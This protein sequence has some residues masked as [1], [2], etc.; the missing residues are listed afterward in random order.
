[1]AN[2]AKKMTARRPE[3]GRLPGEGQSFFRS[4]LENSL[5]AVVVVNKEGVVQYESPSMER[6][7]GYKLGDRIG[8]SGLELVHP[9]DVEDATS[10][11]SELAQHPGKSIVKE[12]RVRHADGSWRSLH[13]YGKNLLKNPAVRGI[14]AGFLDITERKVSEKELAESEEYYRALS[15]SAEKSGLGITIVQNTQ[16]REAAIVVSNNAYCRLSGYSMSELLSMSAWDLIDPNQLGLIKDRYRLRQT[17]KDAPGFYES[18]LLRK[19]GTLLPIETSV[20]TM[21]YRGKIATVS[22]F[23]DI[24]ER[25][26]IGKMLSE[27]E[28][29]YRTLVESSREGILITKGFQVFF[30]NKA[31]LDM[32]GFKTSEELDKIPPFTLLA[33]DYHEMIRERAKKRDKGEPLSQLIELK[34]VCKDGLLRDFELSQADI[35]LSDGRYALSLFRDVTQRKQVEQQLRNSQ[36]QLRNLSVHMETVREKERTDIAREIHDELGQEL[37]ALRMDISWISSR[38]PKDRKAAINKMQAI[39]RTVDMIIE[40]VRSIS[41]E[42][43]PGLLDDLG[44][45]PAIEW[46][47]NEFQN[48]TGIKCRLKLGYD[49]DNIDRHLATA[50]FR[51]LKEALTNISLHSNAKTVTI[52]LKEKDGILTLKVKDDGRGITEEQIKDP[53]SFGLAG[54]R[55]RAYALGG[56]FQIKGVPHKGTTLAFSVPL[57]RRD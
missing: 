43:R 22:L 19:D 38:S 33:P 15:D 30:A 46:Q 2:R 1:M 34:I 40:K 56:E 6:M 4:I 12:M 54:M 25:K 52:G 35:N 26:R 44:L 53:K 5:G 27:S 57:S 31:L 7:L 14:L 3:H 47:V 23:R 8:A 41:A 18:S 29:K 51:V 55:E 48:R 28:L 17:G 16:D 45:V 20:S 32:L 36:E 39:P 9:E 24:T 10:A 11:L 42:L 49:E 50:F 13:V 21:L 37:A